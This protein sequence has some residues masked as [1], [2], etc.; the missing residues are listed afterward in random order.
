LSDTPPESLPSFAAPAGGCLTPE[1]VEA[2][3]Q[4]G[5][6]IL[7][8]FVSRDACVQL[9]A[10]ALEL[11]DAFD[12]AEVHGVFSTTSQ[13][14][15]NDAYFIGSGG[16]I[17]FFLEKDAFD[18]AGQLRDSKENCLNKMGHAMHDLDPVFEKFS[19]SVALA[20]VVSRLGNS[21]PAIIQSMY[22]FKPPRIGGEVVCHQDS[23]YIY[24]EPESCIGFWF[25]LEDA[26]TENGC[27]HFIPGQH[28]EPLKAR[29]YRSGEDCLRTEVLNSEPW[30]EHRKVAAPAR[31][32]TLVVFD[33][34]SPHMSGPNVSDKSRHAY[35]LHV[36]DQNCHYPAENWLQRSADLPLRGPAPTE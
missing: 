34:R 27:M 26:T 33:G 30:P 16:E 20:E 13:E 1:M 25:A 5:V 35:T 11:V 23:T 28:K 10:R 22:I 15:L 6:L 4:T 21:D 2:Y 7:E 3:R 36:I 32:G 9:R 14:Q 19:H 24:T 17:R 18:D 8:D 12:P 31:A 29:N